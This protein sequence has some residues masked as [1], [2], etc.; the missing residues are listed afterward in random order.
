MEDNGKSIVEPTSRQQLSSRERA[1]LSALADG[2]LDQ[3]RRTQAQAR[4][5]A[6]PELRAAYERER[7]AVQAVEQVTATTRAPASL[8]A[9][10]QAQ[11]AGK[12]AGWRW[13]GRHLAV[14][15]T[16]L[17]AAALLIFLVLPS[18]APGGPSVSRAAAL[19]VRG[20]SSH[21]PP[22]D[23]RDPEA[24]LDQRVGRAYFPNWLASLGWA[25]VGQRSDEL[26][27]RRIITVYY[28]GHNT[29]VAY[30]IVG[31]PALAPPAGK[32]VRQGGV[33]MRT[34]SLNGR[35]VVSWRRG[36]HTCLLSGMG[37]TD[38]ELEQLASWQY[39]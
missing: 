18:G 11:P 39:R 5:A 33:S 30:S 28:Q 7:R 3:R 13:R 22:S 37:V 20:P 27:S 34:F 10:V 9:R 16:G 31:G 17:A 24:R 15:A 32:R 6:S 19:A 25:A 23:P 26:A 21:A 14:A 4:I 36:G 8:R 29:T 38:A 12:A 1:E 35:L 2:S